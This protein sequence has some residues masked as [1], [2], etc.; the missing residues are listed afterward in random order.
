MIS[1]KFEDIDTFI[2]KGRFESN[3]FFCVDLSLSVK[4]K[5]LTL[6]DTRRGH[7]EA[8]SL[9]AGRPERRGE[10]AKMLVE[11]LNR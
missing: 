11:E 8:R 5:L 4:G 3:E 6:R 9:E 7:L 1:T 2:R 10:V